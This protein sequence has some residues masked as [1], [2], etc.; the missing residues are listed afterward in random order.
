MDIVELGLLYD[1]EV[2]GAQGEGDPQP[3][4]DGLPRR[5]DDPGG[6]PQRRRGGAGRRG[7]RDR[8]DVGPAVDARADVRRRQVHP[9]L[10]LRRPKPRAFPWPNRAAGSSRTA[11][12]L[13]AARA[14]RGPRPAGRPSRSPASRP[15]R[16]G[17]RR[18]RSPRACPSSSRGCRA[19][20]TR[21]GAAR[22]RVRAGGR[23][24][25]DDPPAR[26]GTRRASA[27]RSR[28]RPSRRRRP[29]RPGRLLDRRDHVAGLVVDGDV[30]AQSAAFASFSSLDEVTIVR[31]PSACAIRNAAVATPPPMPQTSTHSPSRSPARV[32]SI[33]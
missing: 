12:R 2:D 17:R 14:R 24:A 9:R 1:V 15:P 21:S 23:A 8:A 13:R 25:D 28:R 30:G 29:R 7:R 16:P 22:R 3:H 6:H 11:R 19:A 32:T 26:P 33:R 4:L 18:P 20:S 10:R 31:A 5:P 27:S